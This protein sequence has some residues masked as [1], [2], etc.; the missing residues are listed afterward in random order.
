MSNKNLS[1][2]LHRKID[3]TFNLVCESSCVLTKPQDSFV[4][5]TKQVL[6]TKRK[7]KILLCADVISPFQ[8][9][10]Q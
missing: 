3:R 5:A 7:E 10:K 1:P 9:N 8:G 2:F 4:T 6:K